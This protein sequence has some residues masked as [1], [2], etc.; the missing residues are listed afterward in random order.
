MEDQN[1]YDAFF[2]LC[3]VPE[4]SASWADELQAIVESEG[5]NSRDNFFSIVHETIFFSIVL[6]IKAT[7]SRSIFA[8]KT[9]DATQVVKFFLLS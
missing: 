1:D 8:Q 6:L 5:Q 4:E 3:N 7:T 2:N 9:T